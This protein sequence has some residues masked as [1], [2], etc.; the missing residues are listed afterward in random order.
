[1]GLIRV[2]LTLHL[3]LLSLIYT[4]LIQ[5]A[6]SMD[7]EDVLFLASI[8]GQSNQTPNCQVKVNTDEVKEFVLSEACNLPWFTRFVVSKECEIKSQASIHISNHSIQTY[9]SISPALCRGIDDVSIAKAEAVNDQKQPLRLEE[10][11]AARIKS[12]VKQTGN[13][14]VYV[15]Q[16]YAGENKPNLDNFS[17]IGEDLTLNYIGN[18]YYLFSNKM[19]L[20][21]AKKVTTFAANSCQIEG[22]VRPLSMTWK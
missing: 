10:D 17:C 4:P 2:M 3:C 11:P 8:G 22:W 1:M 16:F 5:A 14:E 7:V 13:D 18:K 9:F 15:A 19:S 12:V 21:N 20:D 6:T